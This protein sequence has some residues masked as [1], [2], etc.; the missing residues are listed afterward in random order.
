MILKCPVTG[1]LLFIEIFLQREG[2][3]QHFPEGFKT[4]VCDAIV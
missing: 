1:M 3:L 4:S 2:F